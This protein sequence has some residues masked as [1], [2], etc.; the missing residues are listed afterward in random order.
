MRRNL[1]VPF[2]SFW[3]VWQ[4]RELRCWICGRYLPLLLSI[5]RL[6]IFLFFADTLLLFVCSRSQKYLHSTELKKTMEVVQLYPKKKKK[7]KTKKK[8]SR[9]KAACS[10]LYNGGCCI[11]LMRCVLF[12]WSPWQ[13]Y[14]R[15][16]EWRRIGGGAACRRAICGVDQFSN[17]SKT[18]ASKVPKSANVIRNGTVQRSRFSTQEYFILYQENPRFH[19]GVP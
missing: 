17:C 2:L 19:R 5:L 9:K 6:Q 16:M 1:E 4:R 7:K 10:L 14:R 18:L 8:E 11:F 15:Q 12:T 3:S 13:K